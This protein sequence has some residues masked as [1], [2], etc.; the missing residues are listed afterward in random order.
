MPLKE[1]DLHK[2][3]VI[4]LTKGLDVDTVDGGW[5][6]NFTRIRRVGL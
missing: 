4:F 2:K 1:D 3:A 6:F 5:Y